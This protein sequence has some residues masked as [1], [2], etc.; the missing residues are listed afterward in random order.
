MSKEI[1]ESIKLTVDTRTQLQGLIESL[2]NN[3]DIYVK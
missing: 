3:Y 2:I 1:C